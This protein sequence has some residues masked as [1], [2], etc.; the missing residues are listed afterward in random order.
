MFHLPR[1]VHDVVGRAADEELDGQD[2]A[3]LPSAF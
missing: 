1:M 2:R 3:G